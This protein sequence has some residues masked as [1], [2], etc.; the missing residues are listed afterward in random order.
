[1][2][3]LYNSDSFAVVQIQLNP[4]DGRSLYLPRQ[5][6]VYLCDDSLH[7][8]PEGLGLFRHVA[9]KAREL[10]R[11]EMIELWGFGRNVH[12]VVMAGRRGRAK[13]RSQA[14]AFLWPARHAP[15]RRAWA[16][17]KK[18]DLYTKP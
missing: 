16:D 11:Y 6:I 17:M 8:S 5:K 18:L 10:E 7:D 9:K 4:Q 13:T 1:M 2:Q 12:G 14:P 15:Y 3:L